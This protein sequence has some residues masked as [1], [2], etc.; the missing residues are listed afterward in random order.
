M[1]IIMERS[2]IHF[3][4]ADFAV[5]VERIVD[6]ALRKRAVIIAPLQA[7]RA[8]VYDMSEEAF[9][10][11]VQ[12]GMPLSRAARLCR[13][14]AVLPPRP[15]IYR[16][17]MRAFLGQVRNYSPLMEHGMV[18]GHIFVD[19]TGTHRLFGPAP[20]IGLK[21]RKRVRDGLGINPIWSLAG[22]K[23]VAKVASRLVKPAGEYIVGVGEEEAFLAPLPL[24]LLPGLSSEEV[25][26][27][28]AFNLVRIGQLA[29]L[30]RQQLMV[31][32][33]S[34]SAFLY[35][36]S[37][38]IDAG[39]ITAETPKT[40]PLAFEHFFADD[41]NDQKE[42]AG[43]AADLAA[44]AGR[45]LRATRQVARRLEIRLTYADGI[46]SAGQAASRRGSGSDFVLKNLARQ[47]LQRALTRR[48]RVR[49]CHLLCSRL[50][51][52][53]PQLPLFP[54]TA[55]PEIRQEKTCRALDTIRGRFGHDLIRAGAPQ[56]RRQKPEDRGQ[57]VDF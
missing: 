19:V 48:I 18:D 46:R 4:V 35:E 23:L 32:F 39:V 45:E 5:A 50:Q 13:G 53:S 22:N 42:L 52:E 21:V 37:H 29:S 8:V 31:P 24:P 12:K 38:G 27:L 44:K 25:H 41:T 57:K 56:L 28:R 36:A 16:R 47:A 6:S 54:E 43:V 11:G 33:G 20:D 14:A 10:C 9:G 17:A 3:N 34:R 15:D 1:S 2:I 7:A 49:S 26:R 51:R 40:A 55:G 30:S